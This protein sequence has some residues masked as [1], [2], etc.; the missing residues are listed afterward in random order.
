M[1]R[2]KELFHRFKL[3]V[4]GVRFFEQINLD[5]AVLVKTA[6]Y[7]IDEDHSVTFSFYKTASRD[8]FMKQGRISSVPYDSYIVTAKFSEDFPH[9][10]RKYEERRIVFNGKANKLRRNEKATLELLLDIYLDYLK[11]AFVREER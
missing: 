4:F 8:L 11:A 1:E 6:V 9:Y 3:Y 5:E 2:L 7:Q 10:V